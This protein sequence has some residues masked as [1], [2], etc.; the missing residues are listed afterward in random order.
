MNV[1][2]VDDHHLIRD[3]VG[4]ALRDIIGQD[5]RVSEAATAAQAFEY[6][7]AHPDT[8]MVLLDLALPDCDGLDVLERVG[9]QLPAIAVVVLSALED[10]ARIARAFAL[11]AVGYIPKSTNRDVLES[12]INLV[13]AGGV[14]IPTEIL[15]ASDGEPATCEDAAGSGSKPMGALTARQTDVLKLIMQGKSNKEICRELDL[16]PP[17]VKIHVSAILKTLNV[18]NRTEAALQGRKLGISV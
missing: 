1:L 15:A 3:A 4:T 9:A 12:A 18:R 17:T 2:I 14:Y 11:G 7:D 16:A 5:V 8:D 10:R 13:L 6:L